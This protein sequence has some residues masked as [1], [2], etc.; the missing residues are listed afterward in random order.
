[1][2]NF[3]INKNRERTKVSAHG[4]S[5]CKKE[6][7]T[8]SNEK[9]V[10]HGNDTSTSTC[11]IKM[12]LDEFWTLVKDKE[13]HDA[14]VQCK[15]EIKNIIAKTLIAAD[16]EITPTLRSTTRSRKCCFELYGFDIML[17]S[18]LRPWL[19]EVNVSP[20]LMVS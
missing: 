2:T 12:T 14:V 16:A 10:D 8:S 20:S 9:D 13:G 17:D 11:T 6:S 3:S 7:N 19:L 5:I 15:T 1:M 18:T 4:Q